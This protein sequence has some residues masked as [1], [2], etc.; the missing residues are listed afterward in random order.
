M[1]VS[2]T[3]FR[4]SFFGGGTD[5]PAWYQENGG[6]VLATTIDKYCY[7]SCRYLPPFFDH[8]Y[9]IVYSK[10]ETVKDIAD[11]NHPAVKAVL[12]EMGCNKG[13]EVHHDGDLPAR[14]GLGSSSSFTVGL[15]NAIMAMN[16]QHISKEDVAKQAIH[17][18]QNVIKEN[19]GSQDQISAAFG[20]FNKIEF[21]TNDSFEVFPIIM[22]KP[23]QEDFENH[24]MLF[25][26]GF[27]R[28][29]SDIAKSKI[30]NFKNRVVE[31]CRMREMVNEAIA[32]LQSK[33]EPIEN[34][35]KLLHEC[36]EY[37]K[38][39]SDRVST[40][41]IDLIYEAAK[42]AGATGGKI[43]GAGGG[44]FLLLF[45]TP[46]VRQQVMEKL[47]YLIHVPFRF[48]NSGSKIVLYQPN[49]LG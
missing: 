47:K 16:G 43:L 11:I 8:K 17:I 41:Q 36:W 19:V 48:E 21:K 46:A 5:Y 13:L 25:F 29:A 15:I 4:V 26:T 34:F 42:R 38:S 31:L 14:S 6:S 7:L 40:P 1:I 2:R 24:L 10:I 33:N 49:G 39:L 37:K 45:V 32:I 12:Q 35:G 23:R 20:G 27:S 22:D 3:P 44:G 9:R 18:E 28:I 30:E